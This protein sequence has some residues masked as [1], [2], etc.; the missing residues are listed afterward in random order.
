M[1]ERLLEHGSSAE[2]AE[3]TGREFEIL[4]LMA[5]GRSNLGICAM[6]TLSLRTVETHVRVIMAKLGLA[7]QPEDHRRVLAVLAYLG[8]A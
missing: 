6:L 4:T 8:A 5:Q 3:L 1:T 7:E 2:L